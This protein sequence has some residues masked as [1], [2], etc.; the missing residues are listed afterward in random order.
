MCRTICSIL[1]TANIVVVCKFDT[2]LTT[3][4]QF[5]FIVQELDIHRGKLYVYSHILC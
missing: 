2:S 3:F 1:D 4:R 5:S